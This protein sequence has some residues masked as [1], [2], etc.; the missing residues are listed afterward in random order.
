MIKALSCIG[1]NSVP[2]LFVPKAP[3]CVSPYVPKAQS[4]VSPSVPKAPSRV[5]L[6]VPKAQS[7]VSPGWSDVSETN[8]AQPWGW[9]PVKIR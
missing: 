8:V 7:Y 3:S 4:R 2:V 5:S 1:P 6:S 9:S